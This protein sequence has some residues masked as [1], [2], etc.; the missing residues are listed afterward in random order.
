MKQLQPAAELMKEREEPNFERDDADELSTFKKRAPKL[1]SRKR[2]PNR[3][4]EQRD[5]GEDED[6]DEDDDEDEDG[7]DADDYGEEEEEEG[8]EE[9]KEEEEEE[10][11]EDE[12]E[13]EDLAVTNVQDKDEL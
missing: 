5:F 10:E 13:E 6:E 8:G 7:D 1:N 9:E 2:R 11:D 3:N 4:L 12:E